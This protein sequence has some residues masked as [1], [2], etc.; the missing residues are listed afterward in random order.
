M[1]SMTMSAPERPSWIALIGLLLGL[2]MLGMASILMV[3]ALHSNRRHCL[4][5]RIATIIDACRV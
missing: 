5:R 3:V 1:G 4:R 2:G